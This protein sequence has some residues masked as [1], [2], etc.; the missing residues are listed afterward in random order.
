MS[1]WTR[2]VEI[3]NWQISASL[4]SSPCLG[5]ALW[6]EWP[7]RPVLCEVPL[8]A[9]TH[10]ACCLSPFY[11]HK[12]HLFDLLKWTSFTSKACLWLCWR[13]SH[14]GIGPQRSFWGIGS[15]FPR[16]RTCWICGISPSE[17]EV[18]N[19]N[20]H[21]VLGVHSCRDG[22][23]RGTRKLSEIALF[24][25]GSHWIIWIQ[26]LFPGDSQIDLASALLAFEEY[27]YLFW[28]RNAVRKDFFGTKDTIFKI[29]RR[30]GTPS[31]EARL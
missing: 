8:R 9:Y 16:K 7:V 11:T 30:L 24:F 19:T 27:S 1:W 28:R 3:W 20:R 15:G 21:L 31:N 13:W 18:C 4:G 25:L 17:L 26:V 23:S 29:F 2:L 22:D 5:W 6:V 14:S 10:E 12:T